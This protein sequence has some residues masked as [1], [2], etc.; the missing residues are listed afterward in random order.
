MLPCIKN[1]LKGMGSIL[2]IY[3][4]SKYTAAFPSYT[5][6]NNDLK[7]QL[8]DMEKIGKDFHKAMDFTTSGQ[9]DKK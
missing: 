6:P 4:L 9:K 2:E 1:I 3:P 8:S 7:N 5:S